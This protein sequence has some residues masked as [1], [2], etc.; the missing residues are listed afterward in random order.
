MRGYVPDHVTIN[1]E[2]KRACL[3]FDTRD[4]DFDGF[5]AILPVSLL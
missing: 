3:A 2:K 4:D 5:D 1:G